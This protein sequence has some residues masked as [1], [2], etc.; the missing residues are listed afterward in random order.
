MIIVITIF[1]AATAAAVITADFT[2]II[3]VVIFF[4]IH[5]LR[6]HS[7]ERLVVGL[8]EVVLL[9]VGLSQALQKYA[10][11]RSVG[12][13]GHLRLELLALGQ[14]KPRCRLG[15]VRATATFASCL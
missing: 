7:D 12:D 13:L 15:S 14:L 11:S 8:N 6:Q 2:I 1:F 10:E 3:V 5:L 9:W 4:I